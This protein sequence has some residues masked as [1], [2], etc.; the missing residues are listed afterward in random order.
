VLQV[1]RPESARA[2]AALL[3][4]SAGTR[5]L[6][7]GTLLMRDVNAGARGIETLVLFDEP[8]ARRIRITDGRAEIGAAATMADVM[9]QPDL[10]FL[11]PVAGSIGGPA[12]RGMAT[13]GG[14]LFAPSPYGDFGVALLALGAEVVL[15]DGKGSRAVALERFFEERDT[16]RSSILRSVAFRLPP[17]GAFRF[18]KAVRRQPHGAAVLSI[19]A[20]LPVADG[21]I[22]K[23]SIAYG[24]MAS[25][26]I[27][28]RSVEQALDGQAVP[29]AAPA[30]AE[31]RAHAADGCAP[32]SDAIAS[33]W[34]RR[35]VLPVH[36][37][38]LL[39]A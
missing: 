12:I 4:A 25:T 6:A 13:V 37:A 2:A 35:S 33:D 14:N 34:Y 9:A 32:A 16:L 28:A 11:R 5:L 31:A 8:E 39:A 30:M 3:A 29:L 26:P 23:P 19:A 18:A 27:G 10:A 38:R 21:R 22:R 24:A 15:E 17:E 36:L 7:G 1:V 20:V